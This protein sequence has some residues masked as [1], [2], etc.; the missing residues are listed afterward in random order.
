MLQLGVTDHNLPHD[1]IFIKAQRI[2]VLKKRN[3]KKVNDDITVNILVLLITVL[4]SL[5]QLELK[6][7]RKIR[8][9]HMKK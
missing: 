2:K 6:R 1:Q 5:I 3:S 8:N 4:F 9:Y 7:W